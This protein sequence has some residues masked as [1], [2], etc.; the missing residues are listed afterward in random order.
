MGKEKE[1]EKAEETETEESDNEGADETPTSDIVSEAKKTAL[2]IKTE[3]DRREK[4]LEREEKL[5][6]RKEALN[7][8]GGG[9]PAGSRPQKKEETPKEYKDRMERGG[10]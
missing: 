9:S 7:A 8:L 3:N 1:T 10:I 5:T 2:E 6:A 4:L